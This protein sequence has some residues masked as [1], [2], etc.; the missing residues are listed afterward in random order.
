MIRRYTEIFC[1]KNVSS[2]CSAKATH[3]FSS[4]NIRI[5]YIEAAKTVNEMTLNELVKL[6]TLW[7]AGPW[8]S[9]LNGWKLEVGVASKFIQQDKG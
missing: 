3:I 7:T 4:K 9:S 6:T 5:L 8:S 1:W 2:F